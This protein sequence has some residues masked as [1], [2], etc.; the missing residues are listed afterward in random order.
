MSIFRLKILCILGLAGDK[1]DE[2]NADSYSPRHY[3][4]P[5]EELEVQGTSEAGSRV[6]VS[7]DCDAPNAPGEPLCPVE[8]HT[9]VT[10]QVSLLLM[11]VFPTWKLWG[12]MKYF[13][14]NAED[15]VLA[16]YGASRR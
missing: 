11:F 5:C 4:T 1:K 16:R 8:G 3:T 9:A 10:L 15:H 6:W 13:S 12:S 14:L 2:S 7:P